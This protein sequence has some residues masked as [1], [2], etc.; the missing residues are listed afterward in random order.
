LPHL[1]LTIVGLAW[2]VSLSLFL[3]ASDSSAGEPIPI[4]KILSNLQSY[5]LHEL[6]RQGT[7][8]QLKP[9]PPYIGRVGSVFDACT[10]HLDDG[11]GSIE[12]HVSQGCVWPDLNL[13]A[14]NGERVEVQ[15]L[16]HVLSGT[17][18]GP[19]PILANAISMRRLEHK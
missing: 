13:G 18:E 2:S 11:T 14:F 19:P 12:V 17:G 3:A 8:S 7:I 15:A 6:T 4:R 5:Q 16:L 9:L 10:F 1:R